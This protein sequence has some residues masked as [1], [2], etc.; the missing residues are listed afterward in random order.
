MSGRF[1]RENG[2]I[3]IPLWNGFLKLYE[4]KA[5]PMNRKIADQVIRGKEIMEQGTMEQ[6]IYLDHAATTCVDSE[7][8]EAMQSYYGREYANASALYEPGRNSRQVIEQARARIASCIGAR[9]EEIYFTSGGTESDNWAIKG[10]CMASSEKK[11]IVTTS[12]EHPAVLNTCR[13]LEEQGVRVTYLQPDSWGVISPEKVAEALTEDTVL[14]SVMHANNELG[15][16]EP[17]G[18]IGKLVKSRGILFHTD[19]VQSFGYEPLS[20]PHLPVDLLSVSGH[21]IYGP[22]GIGFLYIKNGTEIRPFIDGGGQERSMRSGTESVPQIVGLAAAVSKLY[23]NQY[24]YAWHA[25]Q[26]RDYLAYRIL[27]EIPDTIMYGGKKN[28]GKYLPNIANISFAGIDSALLLKSLDKA[29]VFASAGSACHAASGEP[30]YVLQAVGIPRVQARG[31]IRFSVGKDN[32]KEEMERAVHWI[33][34]SVAQL[35]E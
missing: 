12:I 1:K 22:K 6:G 20:M 34:K 15:V 2:F 7:V 30:S 25:K 8:L 21:K 33:K 31:A 13:A 16:I 19:A 35:R 28:H 11:H 9:T 32:T 24:R 5:N 3:G 4:R 27:T 26:L 18:A 17:I 23:R 14:V 29:G 10:V